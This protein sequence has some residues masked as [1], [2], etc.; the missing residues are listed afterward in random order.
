DPVVF[1]MNWFF[2]EDRY[3]FGRDVDCFFFSIPNRE[4]ERRLNALTREGDYRVRAIASP[5]KVPVGRDGESHQ[6]HL[7]ELAIPLLDHWSVIASNPVLARFMM[8]RPLPTQGV[9]VLATALALGFRD[10]TLCGVDMYESSD[11]RYGYAIPD[12][13]RH[14]LDAK[15]LQPGYE[16]NHALDRDLDAID[17]CLLQFPDAQ[18]KYIGP[19]RHLRERLI[20]PESRSEAC[21]FGG[22]SAPRVAA[23]GKN[24]WRVTEA[25]ELLADSSEDLPFTEIG[26]R[27]CGYVTLVG[28]PFHHGARALARSLAK[29]SDVPLLVMC[30]PNADRVALRE[31]GLACID[32]PDVFNPNTMTRRTARFS[33]TYNKLNA[34]RMTHLDRAI[35]LDSDMLVMR[36][37]DD[38]FERDGFQAVPDHGLDYRYDSFNSGMFAYEPSAALFDEMLDAVR[39]TPSDDDGDQGF[40]NDFFDHWEPLPHEYN[41]NKRWSTSHPNSFRLEDARVLHLV[42]IKP[43]QPEPPSGFDSLYRLWFDQLTR[44]ELI[45]VAVALRSSAADDDARAPRRSSAVRS[46]LRSVSS[47][48]GAPLRQDPR[49]SSIAL[50]SDVSDL[51][52][53]T[54]DEIRQL[55]VAQMFSGDFEQGVL[56]LEAGMNRFPTHSSLAASHRKAMQMQ[57]AHALTGRLVP[58]SVIAAT[59]SRLTRTRE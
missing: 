11:A 55:G 17:A 53:L 2:L 59:A 20:T 16:D 23:A 42:G 45:D 1:R 58:R 36:S 52:A 18:V 46:L 12:D 33:T 57:R 7:D 10:L 43:W 6:S 4:L 5:M 29:V 22:I 8:S 28:G 51:G 15:D 21:T 39:E 14:A 47:T 13:V 50:A 26:G 30:A 56:T 40:L 32:I 44:G 25:G 19:S 37:V 38:L 41:I 27:R 24:T 49:R 48:G 31:S 9:Q 34:F 54:A 3:Y 35:Y